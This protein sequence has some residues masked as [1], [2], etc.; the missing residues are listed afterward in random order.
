MVKKSLS[1]YGIDLNALYTFVILCS[2]KSYKKAQELL[3]LSAPA[4]HFRV[5]KLEVQLGTKLVQK[6]ARFLELTPEGLVLLESCKGIFDALEEV[7]EKLVYKK[8]GHLLRVGMPRTLS[9]FIVPYIVRIVQEHSPLIEAEFVEGTSTYLLSLFTEGFLDIAI[10]AETPNYFQSLKRGAEAENDS[11]FF[12]LCKTKIWAVISAKTTIPANICL[13]DLQRLPLIEGPRDST[14]QTILDTIIKKRKKRFPYRIR[15][16][17][18]ECAKNL[19]LCN[20]G[21]AFLPQLVVWEA[22]NAGQLR[23]IYLADVPELEVNICVIYRKTPHVI[24]VADSLRR[25]ATNNIIELI[26]HIRETYVL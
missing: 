9:Q 7:L 22:I 19:V 13:N 20:L 10:V 23:V 8:G 6:G 21:F 14:V 15:T 11:D 2:C 5:K 18:Y 17:S 26:H 25:L 24:R 1:L 12:R 4:L 16:N 3:Y